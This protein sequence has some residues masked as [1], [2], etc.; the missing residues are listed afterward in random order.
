MCWSLVRW[1][2]GECWRL[3]LAFRRNEGM[4]PGG[5]RKLPTR[6]HRN[7]VLLSNVSRLKYVI[8]GALVTWCWVRLDVEISTQSGAR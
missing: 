7:S 6:K 4:K 5:I 3:A 8:D 2:R 1:L